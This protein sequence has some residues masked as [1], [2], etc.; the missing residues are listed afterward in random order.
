MG[1]DHGFH[2]LL[3]AWKGIGILLGSSVE[4]P[5]SIQN[6]SPP[7]FFWTKTT[8]L[9]QGDC[10]GWI[11]SLSSISWRCSWTSSK[12]DGAIHWN[13][14]LK[15]SSSSNS[16]MCS[17]ASVHPISFLSREKISWYSISICSNFR[18]SSG[19]HWANS[20]SLPSCLKNCI[21]NCCLSSMES[22]CGADSG[23]CSSN[24][25]ISS[26]VGLPSG[27]TLAASTWAITQPAWRC[28]AL[29]ERL[30][31]TIATSQLP[32]QSSK[33]IGTI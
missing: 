11:A 20:S 21:S 19:V 2:G 14:S 8:T 23:S 7:S 3:H 27:I 31:S 18:A 5:K 33:Y 10:K 29:P 16:M 9:H 13:F 24:F 28:T 12:R 17:A 26:G 1:T 22:F 32:S 25:F 30:Q 15:G 4:S 6:Q